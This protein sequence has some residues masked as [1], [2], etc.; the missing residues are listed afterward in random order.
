MLRRRHVLIA[1]AAAA[2][3]APAVIAPAASAERL[4]A[5]D[6][7]NRLYTFDS[8]SPEKW[9]RT[10]ALTGLAA[11]EKVVGLDVRPAGRRL[12]AL[13]N[14]SRLYSVQRS[15]AIATPIGGNPF[16]PTLDGAAV[17]FDFNPTVDRIRVVSGS[18]QNL[19]LNPDTGAVAFTDGGLRYKDGDPAAGSTPSAIGAAYTN[20]VAGAMS[21]TLYVIDTRRDSLA[22]QAP[23]NDGVLT[24]VGP[25]GVNLSGPLG[26]DISTRD[27]K[28]YVLAHRPGTDRSR[29]FAINLAKGTARKLGTVRRAPDLVALAALSK[30]PAS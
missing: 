12:I 1:T 10:K 6:A 19:R 18:G 9:S 15:R 7:S 27:G 2:V 28:A 16:M 3:A 24:T 21:T 14:R 13:T 17:G 26:F 8:A 30:P 4:V 22:I 25:L 29:L 20:S 11:G 23:P 5:A